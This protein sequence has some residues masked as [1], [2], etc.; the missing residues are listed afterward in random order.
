[1]FKK[2]ET[3]SLEFHNEVSKGDD[4]VV[5]LNGAKDWIELV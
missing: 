3:K 1:M 2:S 4:K 5:I